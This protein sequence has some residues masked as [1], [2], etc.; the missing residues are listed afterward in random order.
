MNFTWAP[1]KDAANSAKHGVS[2]QT[3]VLVFDDL[4]HMSV[5]ERIVDGEEQWRT[6]GQVGGLLI[7]IVAH[8]YSEHDGEETVRV[9]SARKATRRERKRY[10]EKNQ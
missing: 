9:I 5:F 6:I 8:T 2:F 1:E 3:A 4:F 10:E 7:L